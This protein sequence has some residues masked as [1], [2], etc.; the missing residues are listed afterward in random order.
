MAKVVLRQEAINDLKEIWDYTFN[1]WS[2]KQADQ[3]YLSI[4]AACKVIG[5]NPLCGKEYFGIRKN[6]FGLKSGKHIIF[7][8]SVSKEEIEVIRVLHERMDLKSRVNG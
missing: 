2:E 7:Y 8:Q 5:E 1:R 3:Y 4:K 6:L